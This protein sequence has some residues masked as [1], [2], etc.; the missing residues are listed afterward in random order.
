MLIN[1][2]DLSIL[3]SNNTNISGLNIALDYY[4]SAPNPSNK[5]YL[6]FQE[7]SL[8]ILPSI[9]NIFIDNLIKIYDGLTDIPNYTVNYIGFQNENYSCLSGKLDISFNLSSNC[10]IL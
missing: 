3:Q 9:L 1:L 4:S 5:Y 6:D 10:S 2:N 7:G 8:V